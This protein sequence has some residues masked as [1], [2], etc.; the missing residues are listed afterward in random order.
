MIFKP[1]KIEMKK[2]NWVKI[3]IYSTII[4]FKKT[5]LKNNIFLKKIYE[6]KNEL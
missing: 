5:V 3:L 6:K 4:Q 1:L 2:K